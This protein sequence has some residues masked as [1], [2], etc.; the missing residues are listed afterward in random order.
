MFI[1]RIISHLGNTVGAFMILSA[2]PEKCLN[3]LKLDHKSLFFHRAEA[4]S[5][6]SML[7]VVRNSVPGFGKAVCSVIGIKQLIA[8]L[9]HSD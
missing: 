4:S 5:F 2:I 7:Q 9:A 8:L 6:S 3:R 1:F